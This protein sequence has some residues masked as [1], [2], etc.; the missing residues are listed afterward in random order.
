MIKMHEMLQELY[1]TANLEPKYTGEDLFNFDK[2]KEEEEKRKATDAAKKKKRL[3]SAVDVSEDDDIEE[4]EVERYVIPTKFVEWGLED[5]VV[6]ETEGCEEVAPQQP[7]WFK[8]ER[9][10]LSDFYQVV[11]VEKIEVT[12]KI[13]RWKY[14]N[15]KGMFI[16]KRRGGVIQHFRMGLDMQTLPNWDAR[17]LGKLELIDPTNN[18]FGADFERI[19]LRECVRDF[20]VFK[21]IRPRRK[22][23]KNIKDP[24]TGKGKVAWVID[25]TKVVTRVKIPPEQLVML[26]NFK[27]WF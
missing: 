9:E 12:D 24:M 7:E 18:S 16:A 27:K 20:T 11:T 4:E 15:L 21:P 5:E 13:N 6:Y 23:S 25:P 1:A 3:E 19:I 26:T 22:V 14:C 17:E 10:K 2:F 8:K